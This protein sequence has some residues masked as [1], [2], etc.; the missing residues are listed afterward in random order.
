M[1]YRLV[2]T[3]GLTVKAWVMENPFKYTGYVAG[4]AFCNRISEKKDLLGFIKNGQNVLLYSHRRF[5][6]TSLIKEIFSNLHKKRPRIVPVYIDLYGTT[7]QSDFLNALLAGYTVIEPAIERLVKKLKETFS[8]TSINLKL[9]DVE[10]GLQ[11][12]PSIRQSADTDLLL[13][14]VLGLFQEA[15]KKNKLVI[16]LDEFQEIE[17]YGNAFEKKMREIM[18]G[19]ENICYLFAGSQKNILEKMFQDNRRAFYK[20]AESYPLQRIETESYTKWA[21]ALFKETGKKIDA[22]VVRDIVRRCEN[23]PMYVQQ[24][25]FHYWEGFG[26]IEEIEVEIIR[27]R[28]SEYIKVWDYLTLNQ[29]KVLKL[30]CITAGEGIYYADQLTKADFKSAALASKA[31]SSLLNHDILLRNG[32]Y[33]FQDVFFKRWVQRFIND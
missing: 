31:I 18:Q 5:G 26:G 13:E 10:A 2:Y 22:S 15:S 8:T 11:L 23:H 24:F 7:S 32:G 27:R 3:N 1:V 16:A 20:M 33:S 14:K 19:H 25:L 17:Q 6:K 9:G 28:E 30:I 29:K 21:E 4:K 12:L